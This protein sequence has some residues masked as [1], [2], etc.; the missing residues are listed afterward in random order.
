MTIEVQG[1]EKLLFSFCRQERWYIDNPLLWLLPFTTYNLSINSLISITLKT[2]DAKIIII[3][4]GH[5]KGLSRNLL[6]K[7]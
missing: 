3:V 6:P 1:Y 5:N 4:N 7:A 2:I